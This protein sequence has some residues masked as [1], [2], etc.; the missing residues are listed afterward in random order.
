M[1]KR[2]VIIIVLVLMILIACLIINIKNKTNIE[3]SDAIKFKNEY[4]RLNNTSIKVKISEDNII[5]YA[6]YNE[7]IN[8]IKNETAIIY[9]GFPDCPWCRNAIPVLLDAAKELSIEKIYYFNALSIRDEKELDKNG[10]KVVKKEGTNEY[11]ELV[12]LLYDYLPVYKGLNDDKIKRL[13]FPTILFVKEG[14]IIN[15]HTATVESQKDPNIKLSE[16]QYL[17]LKNTYFDYINITYDIL[18]DE[19]C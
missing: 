1:K 6:N 4:E 2:I 16:E 18:C 8:L 5:E 19:T 9:F 13:Y 12:K 17:E 11:K 15:L 14:K 7:T 10:N 3:E